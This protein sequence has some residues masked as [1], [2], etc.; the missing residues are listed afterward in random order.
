MAAI[1][2][3]AL[4]RYQAG[5]LPY[6]DGRFAAGPAGGRERGRA[7]ARAREGPEVKRDQVVPVQVSEDGVWLLPLARN[8]KLVVAPEPRLPL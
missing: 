5:A 8:P 3:L 6:R 1:A 4:Y 7:P 2:C